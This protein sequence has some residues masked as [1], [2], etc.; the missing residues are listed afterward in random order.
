M[1]TRNLI[2]INVRENRTNQINV[3]IRS[4]QAKK[5]AKHPILNK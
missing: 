2:Y 3:D 1:G 5:S 4:F